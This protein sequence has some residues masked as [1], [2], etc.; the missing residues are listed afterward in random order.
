MRFRLDPSRAATVIASKSQQVVVHDVPQIRRDLRHPGSR[1]LCGHGRMLA[2]GDLEVRVVD[3]V[4]VGG[5]TDDMGTEVSLG[6]FRN[7]AIATTATATITA[8]MAYAPIFRFRVRRRC[9][10]S[11]RSVNP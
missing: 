5:D 4:V 3:V 6:P 10:N 2:G 1:Q 9:R 11:C 7:S 8:T